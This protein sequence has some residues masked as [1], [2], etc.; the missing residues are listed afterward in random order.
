MKFELSVED[1]TI[2]LVQAN[3]HLSLPFIDTVAHAHE[4]ARVLLAIEE[5]ELQQQAK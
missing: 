2:I 3:G 4:A 1:F 5:I